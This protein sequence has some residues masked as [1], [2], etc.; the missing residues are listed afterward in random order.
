M[1]GYIIAFIDF[2]YQVL[3]HSLMTVVYF[4]FYVGINV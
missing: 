2:R 3:Q 1:S 4:Y